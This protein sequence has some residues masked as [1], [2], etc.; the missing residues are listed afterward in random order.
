MA[1]LSKLLQ[2]RV[3]VARPPKGWLMSL[4]EVARR[5]S[6]E[7]QAGGLILGLEVFGDLEGKILL[8]F[9]EDDIERICTLMPRIPANA[10]LNH[11]LVG[12][13]LLEMCNIMAGSFMSAIA[14][15]TGLDYLASPPVMAIDMLDAVIISVLAESSLANDQVAYFDTEL[16]IEVQRLRGCMLYFPGNSA[17]GKIIEMG[18][19]GLK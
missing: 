10:D 8:T 4:D 3:N 2:A 6:E 14:E 17:T 15:L 19:G 16:R 7:N 18:T 13:A 9:P 12:S 1:A 11:P 5:L